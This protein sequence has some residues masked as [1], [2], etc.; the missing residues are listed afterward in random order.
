MTKR[1]NTD[2]LPPMNL[3]GHKIKEWKLIEEYSQNDR[4]LKKLNGNYLL[5]HSKKN[6][7]NKS[8]ENINQRIKQ[9]TTIIT[10]AAD[11]S[12]LRSKNNPIP[13]PQ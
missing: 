10:K 9:I 5:K 2:W 12:I 1:K 3:L 6:S 11:I 7:K 4:L 13:K 8:I